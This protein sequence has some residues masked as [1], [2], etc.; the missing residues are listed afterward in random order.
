MLEYLIGFL[1][2]LQ[3][4]VCYPTRPSL[5]TFARHPFFMSTC[6]RPSENSV[7]NVKVLVGTF[8]QEKAQVGDFSVIMKTLPM[9]RLQL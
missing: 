1:V 6:L 7:F 8:N 3:M 5:M 9:V 2:E 4:R